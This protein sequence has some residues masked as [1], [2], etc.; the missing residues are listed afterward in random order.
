MSKKDIKQILAEYKTV[1][2]VG[3]SRENDKPS[4]EVAAYLKAHV[5]RIIPVNPFA[6]EILGEKSYKSLTDMPVAVQETIEIVDVFRPAK[7]VLPIVEQAVQ[8]KTEH[9][10]PF[11]V[12]MQL[13]IVNEEAAERAREAGLIVV[14]DKCM[15]VEHH[16]SF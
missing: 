9:G 6:D 1:A 7:D 2:V 10:K 5:Y 15:M 16:R 3:L 12:W 13:G 8:L 4:Y 14:M 11:V